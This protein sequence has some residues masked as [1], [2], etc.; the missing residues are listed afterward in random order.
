MDWL[1]SASRARFDPFGDSACDGTG[2]VAPESSEDI[3][4]AGCEVLIWLAGC[5]DS[6]VDLGGFAR[7]GAFTV[8]LGER[9]RPIPFWDEVAS[10]QTTSPVT[11]Y[12]HESSFTRGRAVRR[13][14]TSTFQG[15]FFTLNAEEPLVAVIRVLAGLCLDIQRDSGRGE[16]KLRAFP[17]GPM[18]ALGP[19]DY[20]SS[21]EAGRFVFRKLAQNARLRWKAGSVT[22]T[23]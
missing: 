7:F 8:R 21:L 22:T 1:Y 10:G 20:P 16:E 15:L 6:S 17:E 4:A 5:Q 23:P 14:E 19:A 18:E 9:D 2:A 13:V 3:R 11:V 12:W